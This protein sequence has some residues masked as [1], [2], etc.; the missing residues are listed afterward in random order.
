LVAE[1][2]AEIIPRDLVHGPNRAIYRKLYEFVEAGT[3]PT[4]DRV[5]ADLEDTRAKNVLRKL[6]RPPGGGF[7]SSP[8]ETPDGQQRLQTIFDGYRNRK[9]RVLVTWFDDAAVV[10]VRLVGEGAVVLIGD[11]E[12]A[13]N[14]N[15]AYVPQE[16]F[17]GPYNNAHFWRWLL[18]DLRGPEAWLPPAP[19]PEEGPPVSDPSPTGGEAARPEPLDAT[20]DEPEAGPVPMEDRPESDPRP[21][22]QP[23]GDPSD[24]D[25]KE[26]R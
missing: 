3:L 5:V 1:A 13:L 7:L 10:L 25:R 20:A 6:A 12:F 23:S 9:L 26:V 8:A 18:T 17:N 11:T 16:Y 24:M 14:K 4:V 21:E 22:P 15:L 2:R 19:A